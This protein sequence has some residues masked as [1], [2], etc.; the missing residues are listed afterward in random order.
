[1][2]SDALLWVP[3]GCGRASDARPYGVCVF[4]AWRAS[5][6]RPYGVCVFVAWRASDARPY[7]VCARD[8]A[9]AVLK[10]ASDADLGKWVMDDGEYSP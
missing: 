8:K 2:I 6:A 7:G 5:D 3:V 1:M 10:S 9:F 4:V